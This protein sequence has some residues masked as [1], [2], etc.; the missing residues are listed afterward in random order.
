MILAESVILVYVATVHYQSPRW[1]EIQRDYLRRHLNVEYQTWASIE[2]IDRSCA[3]SFDRVLAQ[4][5][6]HS[7]K[8]N[9]LALEICHVAQ[10]DDWIMFLD[11]DAFPIADPVPMLTEAL[12]KA[13]LVAVRRAENLEDP[14]PHPCFCVTTVASWRGL[15]GDWS[16]GAVWR[17]AGGEQ[18]SDVGGNL[19]RALELTHTPWVQLLRTNGS[20]LHPVFFAVY[21]EL[22]Y[23]HG[24]GFRESAL[25]R[26]ERRRLRARA[27]EQSAGGPVQRLARAGVARIRGDR[28]WKQAIEQNDRQSRMVFEAI[29][30]DDPGW[31]AWVQGGD[32]VEAGP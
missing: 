10:D 22:V 30:A 27:L 25:P 14:Q 31:L 28:A 18:V 13:P 8:L 12:Q 2:G 15:A 11:G 16:R 32:P 9:H 3:A 5:G 29:R 19:L 24:A 26:V 23:H 6:P 21:G 1:I 20:R 4:R 7:G 17:N